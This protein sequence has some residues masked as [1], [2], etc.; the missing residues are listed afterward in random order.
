MNSKIHPN[1]KRWNRLWKGSKKSPNLNFKSQQPEKLLFPFL[2]F[3]C[4]C[5]FFRLGKTCLFLG[6]FGW[7]V[8]KTYSDEPTLEKRNG[9][10]KQEEHVSFTSKAFTFPTELAD[11]GK[12]GQPFQG[13]KETFKSVADH[14]HWGPKSKPSSTQPKNIKKSLDKWMDAPPFEN[15]CFTGNGWIWWIYKPSNLLKFYYNSYR[16]LLDFW[17]KNILCIVRNHPAGSRRETGC[18]FIMSNLNIYRLFQ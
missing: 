10:Q 4:F 16:C 14:S 6:M 8:K 5:F 9:S 11:W 7:F 17:K 2:F 13:T 3:L 15:G 12:V 18:F 1:W